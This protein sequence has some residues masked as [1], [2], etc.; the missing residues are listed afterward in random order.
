MERCKFFKDDE[1]YSSSRGRWCK[2]FF[3][4]NDQDALIIVGET[5]D[6]F[7]FTISLREGLLKDK[8][9]IN[10]D[11]KSIIYS[12]LNNLLKGFKLI[13]V[14]EEGT[15][16][17]K[18]LCFEKEGKDIKLTFNLTS[19][20]NVFCT[21]EFANLRRLG[22]TRFRNLQTYNNKP[23]NVDAERDFRYN[24]KVRLHHLMD[25]LEIVC[26]NQY[27]KTQQL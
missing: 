17:K 15:P 23:L 6:Y 7:Y 12:A 24:F 14:F 18:S 3:N 9:S 19:E 13:D 2:Y 8:Y 16:E 27:D 1:N 10:I 4:Y 5:D 20:E 22:D 11:E 21:I 25:E 26:Q